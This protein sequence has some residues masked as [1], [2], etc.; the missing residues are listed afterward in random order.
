[1]IVIFFLILILIIVFIYLKKRN[2]PF[3]SMPID[4]IDSVSK[5]ECYL[6]IDTLLQN[7]NSK[8]NINLIRGNIDRVEKTYVNDTINYVINVF[9]YNPK[10]DTNR[11]IQ[12]DVTY[13]N[14][15]IILNSIKNGGSREIISEERDGV[16]GRGSISFKPKV[17]M[18]KV[19]KNRDYT[20]NYSLVDYK[21]SDK[22]IL[23][24]RNSWILTDEAME[25]DNK[26]CVANSENQ[27]QEWDCFGIKTNSERQLLNTPHYFANN[28]NMNS[29]L[30][31]W[32]FD[33]AQDSASR[34]IGVTG[35]RG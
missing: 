12:F 28:F 10:K 23:V 18:D 3:V 15:N 24:D 22:N 14:K 30:Y 16:S 35:A 19:K 2:E 21:E 11:K 33:P 17:N 1:M 9:V 4:T 34:P 26:I 7:I 13:D 8:H 31:E 29:D 25:H 27:K 5:H 20:N 6:I 32:L